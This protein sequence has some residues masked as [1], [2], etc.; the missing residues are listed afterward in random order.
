MSA[1]R[2][3]QIHNE[4]F[5]ICTHRNAGCHADGAFRS[6]TAGAGAEAT[7]LSVSKLLEPKMMKTAHAVI[8][9]EPIMCQ[10]RGFSKLHKTRGKM[11]HK[12][13]KT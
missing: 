4:E 12:S 13:S 1:T 11:T 10:V 9:T 3:I 6:A 8:G 7:H 2:Q 5:V